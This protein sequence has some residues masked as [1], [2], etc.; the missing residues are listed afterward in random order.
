[1]IK[2]E[3]EDGLERLILNLKN[4]YYL[5]KSPCKL[6]SLRLFNNSGLFHNNER[7]NLYKVISKRVLAQAEQ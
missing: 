1:M 4:I 7:K 6:V 5:L 3:F 2:L